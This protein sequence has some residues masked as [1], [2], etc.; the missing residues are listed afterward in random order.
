ML[1]EMSSTY[2][3]SPGGYLWAIIEPVGYIA[4]LSVGFALLLRTPPLGASFTLFYATGFLSFF[5]YQRV[6][7]VVSHAIPY[8][9]PLLFYPAVTWVDVVL[10]RCLLNALT[11][12]LVLVLVLGAVLLYL[13]G[14]PSIDLVAVF[15]ALA[16]AVLIGLGVGS[17]NAVLFGLFPVWGSIWNVISRPLFLASGVI[18]LL[19]DLPRVLREILW[20]NPLV[21]VTGLFRQ[22]IYAGY[23]P[24]YVNVFFMFFFGL[25][26]TFFGFLLLRKHHRTL[27]ERA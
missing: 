17:V 13:G 26:A 27:I 6:Q 21:H 2:G 20:W 18:F 11:H 16:G 4:V 12:V 8:S 5:V 22:G 15:L 10:A 25:T 14:A 1:R 24:E 23:E 3:R 7:Q 19:E 9:R